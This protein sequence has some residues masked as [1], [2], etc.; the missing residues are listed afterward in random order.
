MCHKNDIQKL[1]KK[2][3]K[4]FDCIATGSSRK[5]YRH[6]NYVIK[7]AINEIGIIQNETEIKIY[8]TSLNKNLSVLKYLAKIELDISSKY[9]VVMEYKNNIISDTD[10]NY[11]SSTQKAETL[12]EQLSAY[13]DMLFNEFNLDLSD[14][15]PCNLCLDGIIIDYGL[16][17]ETGNMYDD[18]HEHLFEN[19]IY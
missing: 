1:I 15:T 2:L 6:S 3:D 12:K 19:F 18:R 17:V 8:Q 5:V 9:F 14:I 13:Y 10:T 7:V 16:T 4:K 11:N